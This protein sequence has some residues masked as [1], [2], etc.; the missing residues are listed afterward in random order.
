MSAC[1]CCEAPPVSVGI[2]CDSAAAS[3][4]KPGPCGEINPADSL[5]YLTVTTVHN[6]GH[7][8]VTQYTVDPD[9]G[10]CTSETTCS[11]TWT[12]T[13]TYTSGI[14]TNCDESPDP[15]FER[16]LLWC[17]S[18]SATKTITWNTDCSTTTTYSGSVSAYSEGGWN[19][20]PPTCADFADYMEDASIASDGTISGTG[21]GVYLL[22]ALAGTEPPAGV[23]SVIYSNASAEE[24]TADLITR[25]ES[26]IPAYPDTWTGTCSSYRNLSGDETSYSVRKHK[27]RIA[28]PPSGTCYLKVWLQQVETPE[29]GSPT[30]TALDPYEWTGTGNPCLEDDTLAVDHA[31]NK[32]TGDETEIGIPT[33]DGTITVEIVKF[34]CVPGYEPDI[35]DPAN[36]QPNGYPDPAWTA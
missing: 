19:C 17:R 32:I 36:P 6:D 3:K 14:D 16:W 25:T 23:A 30:I 33:E 7:T 31:D 9:T 27:W 20:P 21:D 13:D 11:G 12:H 4:S 26:A 22:E 15:G 35:S 18:G 28:H 8:S 5:Y 34:S 10:E 24:T 2:E 29:T 1:H